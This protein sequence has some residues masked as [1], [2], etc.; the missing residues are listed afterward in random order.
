METHKTSATPKNKAWLILENLDGEARNY[1]MNKTDSELS[2]P[3]K[4]FNCL[5]RRFGSG[6]GRTQ[7]RV[8][9]AG[10][11][12]G[13][14]EDTM[15]FLDALESLRSKGFPDE[16]DT[17]RRYEILQRFISGVRNLELHSAL[18]AKYAEE[19]YV[20]EPPTEEELR[21]VA[22]E[23]VRLRKP[24]WERTIFRPTPDSPAILENPVESG[25]TIDIPTP[26]EPEPQDENKPPPVGI[27]CDGCGQVG[28]FAKDCPKRKPAVV[29]TVQVNPND[30]CLHVMWPVRTFGRDL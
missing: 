23:Y 26:A 16:D 9:F 12:Q 29:Q 8:S 3:E 13:E 14:E 1:I 17:V 25:P 6:I 11:V 7:I 2:S 18:A 5:T 28:H 4:V 21:Y 24:R 20:T 15:T 19:K 22:M 27:K 10:R 30:V